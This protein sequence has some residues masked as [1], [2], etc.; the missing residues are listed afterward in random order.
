MSTVAHVFLDANV[1]FSAVYRAESRLLELWRLPHCHL[2]TSRYALEEALRN[3]DAAQRERLDDLVADMV[4]VAEALP[5][6]TSES[7]GL[8]PKDVP[9]LAAAIHAR[10]SHLLTGDVKHFRALLG[11]TQG[12]VLILRPAEFLRTP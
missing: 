11:T 2:V 5:P 1:L 3:L 12:G 7:W 9:I 4:I 8:P 10:C 6:R